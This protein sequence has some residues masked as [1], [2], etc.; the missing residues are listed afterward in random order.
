[1]MTVLTEHLDAIAVVVHAAA[2][3][4]PAPAAV[5]ASGMA[6]AGWILWLPA[7]AA[8]GCGLCAI[9][10]VR[11]KLPGWLTVVCLGAAFG[12]TALSRSVTSAGR[13]GVSVQDYDMGR[14][15]DAD[16]RHLAH[17]IIRVNTRPKKTPGMPGAI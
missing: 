14:P 5:A 6:W 12:V 8:A 2:P 4:T 9:A 15:C 17:P 11:N 3:V 10:R 7:I 13:S 1:M 16:L